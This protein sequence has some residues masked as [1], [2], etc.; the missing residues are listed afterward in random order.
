M[1]GIQFKKDAKGNFFLALFP[2]TEELGKY[3]VPRVSL[4]V[5]GALHS[6]WIWWLCFLVIGVECRLHREQAS[7]LQIQQNSTVHWIQCEYVY[8]P[9]LWS[10]N[11]VFVC[12]SIG[13]I[14]N[15]ILTPWTK[16]KVPLVMSCPVVRFQ[17]IRHVHILH[18]SLPH[19]NLRRFSDVTN[20]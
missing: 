11:F 20:Y 4:Y 13:Y 14:W 2:S 8:I 19:S 6:V 1:E 12:I 15:V 7:L 17:V 9:C 16:N 18:T 3:C 5:C 10:G